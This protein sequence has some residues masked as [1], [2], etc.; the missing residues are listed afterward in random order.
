MTVD[1]PERVI[2]GDV[3]VEAEIIEQ[4]PRRLLNPHH[5]RLNNDVAPMVRRGKNQKSGPKASFHCKRRVDFTGRSTH[6][7]EPQPSGS[8]YDR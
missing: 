3:L 8:A 7:F 4:P 1:A 5:R 2:A 6:S